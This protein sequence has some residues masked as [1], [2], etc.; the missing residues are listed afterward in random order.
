MSFLFCVSFPPACVPVFGGS[1]SSAAVH[2]D[3]RCWCISMSHCVHQY[4]VNLRAWVTALHA[5]D[6][7]SSASTLPD[8]LTGCVGLAANGAGP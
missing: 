5:L 6:T 1:S 3:A 8:S 7:A 2:Y 4:V